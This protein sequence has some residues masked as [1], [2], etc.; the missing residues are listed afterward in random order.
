MPRLLLTVLLALATVTLPG[1]ADSLLSAVDDDFTLPEPDRSLDPARVVIGALVAT[2]C[3][4]DDELR[5]RPE[6]VLVD[7]FFGRKSNSDP[8]EGPQETHVQAVSSRGG[9][10][11]Y[12]FNVPAVR[13]R[14]NLNQIPALVAAGHWIT[15]REVPNP[16]RYDLQV[17]VGYRRPL[18]DSD[19]KRFRELGGR[20]THRFDFING[21]S[22]ELPDHSLPH[23]RSSSDVLYVEPNGIVCLAG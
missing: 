2:P 22:G 5:S 20:I 3:G 18:Q 8:V 17:N 15:V 1:C 7:I 23:L 9:S 10:V 16:A 6:R 4:P 21:I 14:I 13:A 12:R 11:L 19:L